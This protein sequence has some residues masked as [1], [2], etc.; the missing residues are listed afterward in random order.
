MV[1]ESSMIEYELSFRSDSLI[2]PLSEVLNY[3]TDSV[4]KDWMMPLDTRMIYSIG[5]Y[6][7][8]T[9]LIGYKPSHVSSLEG[10]N[11]NLIDMNAIDWTSAKDE[12]ISIISSNDSSYQNLTPDFGDQFPFLLIKTSSFES[13][14]GLVQSDNTYFIEPS[15]EFFLMKNDPETNSLLFGFENALLGCGCSE[16][17]VSENDYE[18]INPNVKKSWNYAYHGIDQDTWDQSSGNNVGVVIIDSGVSFDQENLDEE[19]DFNSGLSQ[20]RKEER[21]NFLNALIFN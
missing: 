20:N 16:E 2:L 17:N 19:Q 12:L 13:I 5:M 21:H 6:S 10:D 7:D 3:L 4:T 9:Y 18:L 14:E 1:S 15:S 8:S 11:I